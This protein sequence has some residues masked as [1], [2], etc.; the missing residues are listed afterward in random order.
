MPKENREF[1]ET[2]ETPELMGPRDPS[3][4]KERRVSVATRA[5]LVLREKRD[6]LVTPELT[7]LTELRDLR[8]TREPRERRDPREHRERL[9][10]QVSWMIYS[11]K[12]HN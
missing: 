11:R 6:P 9:E 2:P 7:E 10:L 5:L 1:P 12:L 4:I 3:V 8:E